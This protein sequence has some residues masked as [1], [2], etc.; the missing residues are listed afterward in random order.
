LTDR[1]ITACPVG[2]DAP[3][4]TSGIVLREGPLLECTAC[5]QLVSQASPARYAETMRAFDEAGYNRPVGREL[6]RRQRVAQR[7]LQR[8]AGFL[9]KEPAAIR[10]VDVGCS[11]GQ[12]VA[13]AKAA[14][15]PAEGV[16]P[17]PRIAAVARAEGLEVHTGLL[18]DVRF[19][20]AFF[21]ALTLFEVIE[22]LKEP[23]PLLREARRILRPGSVV[24]MTTGNAASWTVA[25]MGARWDYFDMERDGGH[26][27]F[28]NPRSLALLARRAGYTPLAIETARV[29]FSE[30]GDALH[31][32]AK[33][34]AELLNLPARLAGRGHDMTAYLRRD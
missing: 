13:D 31:A 29:R 26:V 3:F 23:L 9:G 17:A 15:F 32:L 5:G 19:P 16:E 18:D 7:R 2:C 30:K 12:F 6:E 10:L 34:A 20:D 14:G 28:Y 27:S 33:A 1:Y 22:H 11:R 21:D 24:C 25:A 4:T 8:I